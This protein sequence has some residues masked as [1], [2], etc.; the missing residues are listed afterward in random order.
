M[1]IAGINTAGVSGTAVVVDAN[2][3]LGIT[4][5]SARY[6]QDITP[7]GTNSEGVLR[8][9]PVTFAYKDDKQGRPTTGSSPK[10]WRRCTRVGDPHRV[11]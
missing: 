8:L 10:K 9:R 2:G 1:Y 7:M 5:S 11:G 6:K 4:L 3:L